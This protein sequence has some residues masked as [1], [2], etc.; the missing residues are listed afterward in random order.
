[1]A[2]QTREG[3]PN[4]LLAGADPAELFR[5]DGLIDD[6]KKAVAEGAHDAGDRIWAGSTSRRRG[7]PERRVKLH[8][9]R[10][11]NAYES[12]RRRKY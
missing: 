6:L 7:G 12:R 10:F 4:E 8:R 1:M 3:L 11:Q 5:D 2:R 9:N